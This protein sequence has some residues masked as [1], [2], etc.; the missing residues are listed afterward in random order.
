MRQPPCENP[1]ILFC[2]MDHCEDVL[3]GDAL[4]CHG[5]D[6]HA[7]SSCD[8][9]DPYVGHHTEGALLTALGIFD[10]TL[11]FRHK[12]GIDLRL[13]C[14]VHD[15]KHRPRDSYSALRHLDLCTGQC[16]VMAV[17]LLV[18]ANFCD[19]VRSISMKKGGIFHGEVFS[20]ILY[21]VQVNHTRKM[22]EED[23]S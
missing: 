12:G 9:V 17:P 5:I 21:L 6:K 20:H 3:C 23:F 4:G 15:N 16:F 7:V 19:V 13:G 22:V 14:C 1:P 18:M 11:Y 10:Y 2:S 8:L